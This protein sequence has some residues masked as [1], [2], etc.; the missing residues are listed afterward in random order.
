MAETETVPEEAAQVTEVMEEAQVTMVEEVR[1]GEA[2]EDRTVIRGRDTKRVDDN[3]S[4]ITIFIMH[5]Q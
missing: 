5:L 2:V 3:S 4:M 1:P